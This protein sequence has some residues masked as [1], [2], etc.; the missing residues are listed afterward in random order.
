MRIL[1]PYW[2]GIVR[3]SASSLSP[4]KPRPGVAPGLEIAPNIDKIAEKLQRSNSFEGCLRKTENCTFLI[5]PGC[6]LGPESREQAL[7]NEYHNQIDGLLHYWHNWIIHSVNPTNLNLLCLQ[8]R[9]DLRVG[10]NIKCAKFDLYMASSPVFY[11]IIL[12]L[13]PGK[14]SY[15]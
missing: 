9:V 14:I 11:C 10:D 12:F 13:T 15:R 2:P 7:G 5:I 8:K 1:A 3:I 6:G 4:W